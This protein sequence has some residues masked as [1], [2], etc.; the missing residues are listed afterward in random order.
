MARNEI[1]VNVAP[2]KV[3]AVLADPQS[4]ATWVVGSKEVRGAD[5]AWPAKGTRF[6]HT[7][8]VGPINLKD[9]TSV[10]EVDP[11]RRLVLRTKVRPFAVARVVLELRPERGGH[12]RP[13][14]GARDR[15][16]RGEDLR[17]LLGPVD[18]GP[19]RRGAA[20]PEGDG[21]ERLAALGQS[22]TT[23]I[24]AE[25]RMQITITICMAIQ[26]RGTALL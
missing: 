7:V 21:G 16:A 4:Y 22:F 14:G 5:S 13:D 25:M 18:E 23:T 8:G 24:T 6:H 10:E 17:V 19:K 9:H 3:F 12:A 15:R 1:H 26:N 20:P 2:A 11:P